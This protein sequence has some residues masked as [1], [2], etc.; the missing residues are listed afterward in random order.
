[1]SG[2]ATAMVRVQLGERS[3]SIAVGSGVFGAA[4]SYQG[5]ARGH[6]ALIVSNETVGPL[7]ADGLVAALA[8]L[9]AKVD[10]VLFPTAKFT[11][12]GKPCR[13]SSTRCSPPGAI[14]ARPSSPSA[15][16]S[17]GDIAGFA[18]ALLRAAWRSSRCRRRCWRRS[19]RRSAARPASTIRAART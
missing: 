13:P 7:Y 19:T 12:P 11:K 9:Y 18:A 10:V 4:S 17:I 1:M 15:A 3:Y 2:T 8:G 6:S 14:A 5:M 16:A